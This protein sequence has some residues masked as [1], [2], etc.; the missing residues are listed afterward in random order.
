MS[1][2]SATFCFSPKLFAKA[3]IQCICICVCT[4]LFP[5]VFAVVFVC[6]LPSSC[7]CDYMLLISARAAQSCRQWLLDHNDDADDIYN[8]TACDPK[9]AY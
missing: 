7:M 1:E 8:T 6:V 9:A 5:A 2:A 3:V 4:T